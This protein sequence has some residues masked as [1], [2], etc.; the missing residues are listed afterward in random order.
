MTNQKKN[1]D[2]VDPSDSD[3]LMKNLADSLENEE[4]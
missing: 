2:A 3:K 1:P 4:V